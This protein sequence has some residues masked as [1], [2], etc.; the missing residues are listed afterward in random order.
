MA[1][2]EEADRALAVHATNLMSNPNVTS[3][4]VIENESGESIIEIGLVEAESNLA[5]APDELVVPDVSG[6]LSVGGDTIGVRKRIVGRIEAQSFTTRQRPAKGGDSCGPAAG[7]WSGTLGARVSH[8]GVACILSNWHVLYG[9]AANDQDPILQQGKGDGGSAAKDT[10]G[11]NLSGILNAQIDAAVATLSKPADDYVIA[12]TISYGAIA[13][14]D[15]ATVGMSV[16]KCGRTTQA[17]TGT[18]RSTNAT[19]KVSG[20]PGGVRT[21][22]DQ[23]QLSP[24][25]ASGDSGSIVLDPK[26]KAV[27]LLF[28]GGAADSYANK[29]AAVLATFNVTFS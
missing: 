10:I 18:V 24:M 22:T 9:G 23:I 8:N 25:S 16:K 14:T 21:F 6:A 11:H 17:T 27:G 19:V 29:I 5:R 26:N 3:I 1:T 15:T 13:G 4:S 28:A 7:N 2:R 20:Y 12:G